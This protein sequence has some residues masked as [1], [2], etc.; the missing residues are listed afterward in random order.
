VGP[1]G[2]TSPTG[3][4]KP[5]AHL[6]TCRMRK[7]PLT[8]LFENF[9][10][11]YRFPKL[12]SGVEICGALCGSPFKNVPRCSPVFTGPTSCRF[13]QTKTPRN[14]EITRGLNWVQGLDLNQR[15]SGY[16]PKRAT[17]GEEPKT[18][19]LVRKL[20]RAFAGVRGHPQPPTAINRRSEFDP[21]AHR[22]RRIKRHAQNRIL[23]PGLIQKGARD[24]LHF[25]R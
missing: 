25:I 2:P 11:T 12:T 13:L 4:R 9:A 14:L 17:S 10:P 19:K 8:P 18:A 16:E 24:R 1:R 5:N 7:N 22:A 23:I 15:P 21:Y 6:S 20:V 3:D